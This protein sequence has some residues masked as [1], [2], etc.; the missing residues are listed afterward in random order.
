V[1]CL[2]HWEYFGLAAENDEVVDGLIDSLEMRDGLMSGL[3]SGYTVDLG[4]SVSGRL[5]VGGGLVAQSDPLVEPFPLP[6][7]GVGK[8]LLSRGSKRYALKKEVARNTQASEGDILAVVS[9][10]R[11]GMETG[12]I[13][14]IVEYYEADVVRMQDYYPFGMARQYQSYG[15]NGAEKGK[16]QGFTGEQIG[17]DEN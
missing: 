3:L 2:E 7:Q 1:G 14:W 10:L 15:S 5:S 9:D 8:S 11:L 16:M 4:S 17:N 12:S 13:D 6:V